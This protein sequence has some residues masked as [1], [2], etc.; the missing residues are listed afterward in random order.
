MQEDKKVEKKEKKETEAQVENNINE[1][2]GQNIAKQEKKELR[3]IE[4]L[5][6]EWSYTIYVIFLL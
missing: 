1:A 4:S 6:N 2:Q 5:V 3:S